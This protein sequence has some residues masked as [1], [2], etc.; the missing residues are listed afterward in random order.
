MSV[1]N[2]A[3][4]RYRR[5]ERAIRVA[6]LGLTETN[7]LG[8]ITVTELC[9]VAAISRNAFYLHYPSIADLH[10]A[11]MGE[12]IDDVH[13]RCI[14][15]SEK[16]IASGKQ[17]LALT[18]EIMEALASHEALLRSLLLADDGS[19]SS[20]LA[21]ELTD[22]YVHAATMFGEHGASI[23]HRMLCAYAAGGLV[24][25]IKRWISECSL[26]ISNAFPYFDAAQ[27]V[28]SSKATD[29]LLRDIQ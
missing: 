14:E 15:S 26:P 17:D 27:S 16:V 22:I 11:L 8:E 24:S 23:D 13:R 10:E 5:T 2:K 18:S 21:D 1:A 28:V 29:Y 20:R 9:K 4:T 12:L 19:L 25:L 7:N 6:Y 3:D